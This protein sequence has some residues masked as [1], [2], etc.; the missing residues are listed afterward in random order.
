MGK[1]NIWEVDR[2]AA[3]SLLA[4]LGLE[5]SD[6]ALELAAKSFSAHRRQ[7]CDWAAQRLQGSVI[8][9]LEAAST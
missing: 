7:A 5:G 9:A 4:A 3:A 2:L 8:E 6:E 1:P